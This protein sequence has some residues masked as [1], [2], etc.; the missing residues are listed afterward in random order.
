[1]TQ[2]STTSE[3][4]LDP[5]AY[6]E[7]DGRRYYVVGPL[8]RTDTFTVLRSDTAMK[9]RMSWTK[10]CP[11]RPEDPHR[12]LPDGKSVAHAERL[13]RDVP[14]DGSCGGVCG[15]EGYSES[16]FACPVCGDVEAAYEPDYH[17][18][19]NGVWYHES[20]D[21]TIVLDGH[22]EEIADAVIELPDDNTRLVNMLG[23][24]LKPTGEM[25][26]DGDRVEVTYHAF[27]LPDA[28]GE[29]IKSPGH[30]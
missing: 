9:A 13:R 23:K 18:R 25:L 6:V 8:V 12:W 19:M 22:I 16:Y 17:V 14:C 27:L 7:H 4:V 11:A 24:S 5:S 30:Q 28:R 21:V 3:L 1:M 20:T 15:G 2:T 10:E 26:F 29:M